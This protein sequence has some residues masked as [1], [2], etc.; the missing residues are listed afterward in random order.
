MAEI[1]SGDGLVG[2]VTEA[3]NA[4][5]RCVTGLRAAHCVHSSLQPPPP[6]RLHACKWQGPLTAMNHGTVMLA[7]YCGGHRSL[8]WGSAHGLPTATPL[9]GWP[10][11][12]PSPCRLPNQGAFVCLYCLSRIFLGHSELFNNNNIIQHSCIPGR[13]AYRQVFC[14]SL[15]IGYHL[16]T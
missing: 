15:I 5:R 3:G 10:T 11:S 8:R 1:P 4:R 13:R 9:W 2:E 16:I 14:S 6:P 7:F 12:R